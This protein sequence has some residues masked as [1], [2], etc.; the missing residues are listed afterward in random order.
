MTP[1]TPGAS[2]PVFDPT[3]KLVS[4]P[5]TF[6]ALHAAFQFGA[7]AQPLTMRQAVVCLYWA[8]YGYGAQ[9]SVV[10]GIQLS[11]FEIQFQINVQ[12]FYNQYASYVAFENPAK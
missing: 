4:N 6:Y 7:S 8:N 2:R 10:F 5:E 3:V 9:S 11:F 12:D 1:T